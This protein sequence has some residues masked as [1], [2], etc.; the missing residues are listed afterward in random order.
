MSVRFEFKP[1]VLQAISTRAFTLIAQKIGQAGIIVDSTPARP[2]IG[3][4]Y[5]EGVGYETTMTY[6]FDTIGLASER[7][8]TLYTQI[9]RAMREDVPALLEREANS[10]WHKT[11]EDDGVR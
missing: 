11:V 5:L 8:R 10:M 3:R 4:K 1:E 9:D 7:E 6:G 2:G